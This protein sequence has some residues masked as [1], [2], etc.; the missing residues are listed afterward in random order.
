MWFCGKDGFLSIVEKDCAADELLV[1]ARVKTHIEAYFPDVTIERTPGA[2]R[3]Y[4][5]RAKVKR[6]DV[7]E[8]MAE[9]VMNELTADNFKNS[10]TDMK[11]HTAYMGVWHVM[12]RMQEVPPYSGG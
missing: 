7:A 8:R 9:Y 5:Y 3:D 2:H 4:L 1:R 11:L 12:A 10:V 6:S